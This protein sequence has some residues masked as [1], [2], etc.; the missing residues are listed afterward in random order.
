MW[1]TKENTVFV[2]PSLYLAGTQY[3]IKSQLVPGAQLLIELVHSTT[4]G[5]LYGR[6]I[7]E[8]QDPWL[9]ILCVLDKIKNIPTYRGSIKVTGFKIII[10]NSV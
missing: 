7:T 8:D 2:V 6:V 9:N 4:D 3:L 10:M 5:L 1:C